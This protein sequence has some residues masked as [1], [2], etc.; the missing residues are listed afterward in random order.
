MQLVCFFVFKQKTA[1]EMRISDWSSDVCSSD[2]CD[3]AS[4]IL[5]YAQRD[6][7]VAGV[8]LL[9]PWVRTPESEA[10]TYLRH[11]YLRRLRDRGFWQSAVRGKVNPVAAARS[12][13]QLLTQRFAIAGGPRSAGQSARPLPERMADGLDRFAGA[14]LLVLCGED[15]TAREFDDAA[16][17]SPTW[18]RLLA[19]ERVRRH[20]LAPADHTFSRRSWRDSVVD[21]TLR[22]LQSW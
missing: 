12:L 6:S 22:W 5:F 18:Q 20:D 13:G 7:R 10:D 11:Y 15:L 4:A 19:A 9:N 2:L 17:R 21:W 8:A 1:Y 16:Q 3:A 14:V